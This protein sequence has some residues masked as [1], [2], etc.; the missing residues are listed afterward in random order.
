[1]YIFA[2]EPFYFCMSACLHFDCYLCKYSSAYAYQTGLAYLS[3]QTAKFMDTRGSRTIKCDFHINMTGHGFKIICEQISF[4]IWQ[5]L[6]IA[7]EIEDSKITEYKE[8]GEDIDLQIYLPTMYL[9]ALW[10]IHCNFRRMWSVLWQSNVSVNDD[11]PIMFEHGHLGAQLCYLIHPGLVC[12]IY[13]Y[14]YICT[15]RHADNIYC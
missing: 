9:S 12:L 7:H 13:I 11:I 2:F 15:C 10:C 1:M 4:S 14:T 5:C 6:W 3:K 8:N